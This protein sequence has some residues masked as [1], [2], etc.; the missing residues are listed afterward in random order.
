MI[1]K[2]LKL[3]SS[4]GIT[5]LN[6]Y[7][8]SPEPE[9]KARGILQ[10]NHGMCEHIGRY[11]VYAETFTAAGFIVVGHDHL[12]HGRSVRSQEYRSYFSEKDGYKKVL[13]DM[14]SVTEEARKQYPG[15]PLFILG[16]SMGSF[17]LRRY[18]TQYSRDVDGA[19]IMG[20]G[21]FSTATADAAL[22]IAKLAKLFKGE[23]YRSRLLPAI[24]LEAY[25]KQFAPNRTPHDWLAKNPEV[26]DAYAQDP[27]SGIPFTTSAYVDFFRVIRLLTLGKDLEKIRKDLPVL[28]ISGADDPVGGANAVEKVAEQYEKLGLKDVSKVIAPGDRHELLR[29]ADGPEQI[30]KIID[31]MAARV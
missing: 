28:V 27:L 2:Q 16:H 19:V 30:Q 26:A 23:F 5:T 18:L 10:M 7:I 1:T 25:N 6:G 11:A 15:F 29:E 14:H 9:V 8:W 17:M 24:T 31:W 12:G 21:W 20:T 13:K 22:G 4:D 3:P